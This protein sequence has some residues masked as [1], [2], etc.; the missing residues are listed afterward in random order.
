MSG[1]DFFSHPNIQEAH[2]LVEELT[3]LGYV[4]TVIDRAAKYS[5]I[6]KVLKKEKFDLL[7]SNGAGNSAPFHSQMIVESQATHKILYAAGPEKSFCRRVTLARHQDFGR[8]TGSNPIVRR[9]VSGGSEYLDGVCSILYLGEPE[10]QEFGNFSSAPVFE[11]R[12]AVD[13]VRRA[14]PEEGVSKDPKSFVYM[15]GNGHIAKGLDLVLEAFAKL[16]H[17]KLD[18]FA[19]FKEADFWAVYQEA[20]TKCPNIRVHGFVD[21]GSE[22]FLRTTAAAAYNVFP[23]AAEA[24]ATS[25]IALM[26]RGL[27]PITTRGV[28]PSTAEKLGFTLDESQ[29][30][31]LRDL[32]IEASNLPQHEI[33]RRSRKLV[34]LSDSFSAEGYRQ[35]VSKAIIAIS[36]GACADAN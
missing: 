17:L 34:E 32:I 19:S 11:V 5:A 28:G 31:S 4:T 8:R 1:K 25:F 30:D 7:I 12:S 20:L 23:S 2:L 13:F 21:V 14:N 3:Q 35:S 6:R 24:N 36:E 9:L 29:L 33:T 16:P 15:G 26:R 10:T 27:L 18:V 22:L